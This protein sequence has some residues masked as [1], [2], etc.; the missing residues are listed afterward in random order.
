MNIGSR[1]AHFCGRHLARFLTQPIS[2]YRTFA[3]SDEKTLRA[4][5]R[6]ADVL[7]VEGDARISLAIK[8]L[9]QSTWSH[10]CLFVGDALAGDSRW[11]GEL[12][13][14]ELV[15]GVIAAPLSKYR[16]YNTRICRPIGLTDDDR[17][18]VIAGVLDALGRQYDLRNLLDLARYLVQTPPVPSHLRRQ[19]LEFG[20]GDPTRGICSTIIAQAFQSVRYPILPQAKRADADPDD[21]LVPSAPDYWYTPQHYSLFT[22][23]DFDLSPYFKVIKPTI[24]RGFDYRKFS[25]AQL[26][27]KKGGAG[28]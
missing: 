12:V 15:D 7:L 3:V 28:A 6:P 17:A 8:Y 18:R 10:A 14:A 16:H 20:S 19:M 4:V 27:G 5:L 24:E 22:P 2:R 23:R 11:H 21:P 1:L 9:T 25:W 26:S 13:E